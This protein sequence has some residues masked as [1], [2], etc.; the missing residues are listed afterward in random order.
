MSDGAGFSM[1]RLKRLTAWLAAG[2]A[3]LLLAASPV[4]AK[5]V[6]A[7]ADSFSAVLHAQP[8]SLDGQTDFSAGFSRAVYSFGDETGRR[9]TEQ[10]GSTLM[11]VL[12]IAVILLSQVWCC[13]GHK[14]YPVFSALLLL[15]GLNAVSIAELV[16]MLTGQKTDI[17][18]GIPLWTKLALLGIS[19]ALAVFC[20]LWR[21]MSAFL[22]LFSA[23]LPLTALGGW[24][25]FRSRIISAYAQAYG[26]RQ[27][28]DAAASESALYLTAGMLAAF[29]IGLALL[30]AVPGTRFKKQFLMICT[31]LSFGLR[32]GYL[33]TALI[34]GTCRPSG[35]TWLAAALLALGGLL[36]QIYLGRGF[37]EHADAQALNDAPERF[38]DGEAPQETY[39]D[40]GFYGTEQTASAPPPPPAAPPPPPPVLPV[41]AEQPLFPDPFAAAAQQQTAKPYDSEQTNV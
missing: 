39:I 2:A 38:P 6:Y 12:V 36:L 19:L 13:T 20:F 4:R 26:F 10:T 22:M 3:A 14:S 16:C 30:I 25:I 9:L 41:P 18:A 17:F 27:T 37:A 23:L 29:S 24:L 34:L 15:C 33:L 31:P 7:D 35:L 8:E 32:S 21:R 5:P 1:K 28:A 11:I 40:G